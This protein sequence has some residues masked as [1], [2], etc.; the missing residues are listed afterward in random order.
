MRVIRRLEKGP[1]REEVIVHFQD[2]SQETEGFLG[3]KPKCQLKG[4]FAQQLGLDMTPMG[5][6][7]QTLHFFRLAFEVSLPPLTILARS[8]RKQRTV[9]RSGSCSGRLG[10]VA[11]GYLR[12]PVQGL[13]RLHRLGLLLTGSIPSY[14]LDTSGSS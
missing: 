5:L 11:G 1:K 7:R 6:S 10:P 3:H 14:E 2:G 8:N 4:P 12:T 9:H 13:V